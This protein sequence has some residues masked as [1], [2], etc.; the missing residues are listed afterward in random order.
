MA[1]SLSG[2][3]SFHAATA[4]QGITAAVPPSPR[5]IKVVS[6][7]T[8]QAQGKRKDEILR[9]LQAAGV[10]E[11]FDIILLQEF[12]GQWANSMS[13]KEVENLLRST[14]PS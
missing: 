6:W 12:A 2:E 9:K 3:A 7:N 14:S 4:Q 1:P 13:K 11:T 8:G 10:A 5:T